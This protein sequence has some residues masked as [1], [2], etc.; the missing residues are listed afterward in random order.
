VHRG[1][2][3]KVF[4]SLSFFCSSTFSAQS[5]LS[6]RLVGVRVAFGIWGALASVD[7][8]GADFLF[9]AP[10]LTLSGLVV[11]FKAADDLPRFEEDEVDGILRA[12]RSVDDDDATHSRGLF[13]ESPDETDMLLPAG[14]S[15]VSWAS[16]FGWRGCLC[17]LGGIFQP[18]I[19]AMPT[20]TK[21]FQKNILQEAIFLLLPP[22]VATEPHMWPTYCGHSDVNEKCQNSIKALVVKLGITQVFHF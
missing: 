4:L 14:A 3:A 13:D 7:E 5:N 19:R 18:E 15:R 6:A 22:E 21:D 2:G 16:S 17:C 20:I 8:A 11:D 10:N 1:G 9:G 12:G